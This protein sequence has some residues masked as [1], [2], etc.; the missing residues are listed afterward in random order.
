MLLHD[1]LGVHPTQERPRECPR[2][3]PRGLVFLVFSLSRTPHEGSHKMSHEGAHRSAHESQGLLNGGF[4]T[5]GF[6]DL[7]LSFLFCP[8]WDFPD[9]SGIFPICPGTLRGFSRLALFLFHSLL[10]APMRN[11]PERVRDT[12]WTF[13]ENS[14][15]PPGLETPRFSFSQERVRSSG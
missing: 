15:K 14:G 5:G 4:Q 11:S 10:T 8:F 13:P 3:C 12:I 7:G 2:R 6:P 9:V 1:P